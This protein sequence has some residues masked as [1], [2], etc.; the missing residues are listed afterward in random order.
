[1]LNSPVGCAFVLDVLENRRLPLEYFAEPKVSFWLAASA[2][3]FMDPYTDGHGGLNQRMALR[4]AR[5]HENLALSLVSHPAFACWWYPVDLAN[6]V[7]C[8]ASMPGQCR[9]CHNLTASRASH[10]GRARAATAMTTI[11]DCNRPATIKPA[12]ESGTSTTAQR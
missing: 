3:D 7:S 2:M 6:Q 8:Q 5:A 10:A 12:I 4:N 9:L 1:M 11:S